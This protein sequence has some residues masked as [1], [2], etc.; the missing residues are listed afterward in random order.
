MVKRRSMVIGL[1]ALATGSGAVFSSAAFN[2]SANATA[3]MRVVVEDDIAIEAGPAF[4]DGG[5]TGDYDYGATDPPYIAGGNE[6]FDG[7]DSSGL[8]GAID[9]PDDLPAMYVSDGVVGGPNGDDGD[10]FRIELAVPNRVGRNHS[11][12]AVNSAVG[13]P[14]KGTFSE[15]LQIRNPGTEELDVGIKFNDFGS[16]VSSSPG[17]EELNT[18][19]VWDIFQFKVNGGSQISTGS[20]TDP[21]SNPDNQTVANNGVTVDTG[22]IVSIDLTVDLSGHAGTI[23]DI[24]T[25]GKADVFGDGGANDT[26]QLVK[27]LQFGT[28]SSTDDI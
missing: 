9:D 10:P 26:V 2:A 11:N 20:S 12:A 27:E 23:R 19:S 28:L 24:A 5:Q 25:P 16:S 7:V 17:T 1:G 14:Y 3:D 4:R 8:N 18:T 13:D 6:L 15:V 21:P 22:D